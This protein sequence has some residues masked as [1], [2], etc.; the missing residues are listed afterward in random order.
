MPKQE[1]IKQCKFNEWRVCTNPDFAKNKTACAVCLNAT[2]ANT[3]T[4]ILTHVIDV[5]IKMGVAACIRN[6]LDEI[7]T[8]K[9]ALARC[10]AEILGVSPDQVKT[11]MKPFDDL[12]DGSYIC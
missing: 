5:P 1:K 10:L 7:G 4:H 2:I 11:L 3:L 9:N 12:A 8:L 6:N